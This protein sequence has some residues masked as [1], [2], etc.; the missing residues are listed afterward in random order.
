[1]RKEESKERRER[2]REG[3]RKEERK[4]VREGESKRVKEGGKGQYVVLKLL[5]KVCVQF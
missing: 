1:M 2:V 5:Q 4:R 3:R